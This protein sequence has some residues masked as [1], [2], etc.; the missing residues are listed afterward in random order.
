MNEAAEINP[1]L[2]ITP[3][4]IQIQGLEPRLRFFFFVCLFSK[5]ETEVLASRVP[6]TVSR[7]STGN[8]TTAEVRVFNSYICKMSYLFIFL[9]IC[10][11]VRQLK[12]LNQTRGATQDPF[13]FFLFHYDIIHH[14]QQSWD[15]RFHDYPTPTYLQRC[16]ASPH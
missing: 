15:L 13:T 16:I 10:L 14:F 7:I 9:S 6:A 1:N 12:E 2:N 3:M 11:F 4:Y 5:M 8:R